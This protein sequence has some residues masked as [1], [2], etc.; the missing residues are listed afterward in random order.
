MILLINVKNGGS[1]RGE[2]AMHRD[3]YT[4]T[5]LNGD[6]F[7]SIALD[8]YNNENLSSHIIIANPK[9]RKV[10]IFKGGETIKVPI[11]EQEPAT[12]LPPWKQVST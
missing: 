7:D 5:T 6:T 12:T 9:F 8:F 4:Y 3:N 2:K 10:I 1:Q 11:V